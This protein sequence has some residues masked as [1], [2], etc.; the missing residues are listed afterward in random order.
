MKR[1]GHE[2][3]FASFILPLSDFVLGTP[4]CRDEIKRISVVEF[5][6]NYDRINGLN[7]IKK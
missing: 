5:W 1:F 7:R 6:T 3:A 2:P 4:I